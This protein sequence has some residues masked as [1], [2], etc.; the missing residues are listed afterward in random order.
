MSNLNF[1]S[2]KQPVGSVSYKNG[3]LAPNIFFQHLDSLKVIKPGITEEEFNATPEYAAYGSGVKAF[4]ALGYETIMHLLY[5][6][7]VTVHVYLLRVKKAKADKIIDDRNKMIS[8]A[9]IAL[10]LTLKELAEKE[11]MYQQDLLRAEQARVENLK[12]LA[13]AKALKE[14]EAKKLAEKLKAESLEKERIAEQLKEKELEKLK[15]L[16]KEKSL[17]GQDDGKHCE[18]VGLKITDPNY[19]FRVASDPGE[20]K[21]I[22][23]K[24]DEFNKELLKVFKLVEEKNRKKAALEEAGVLKKE[25]VNVQDKVLLFDVNYIKGIDSSGTVMVFRSVGNDLRYVKAS[26]SDKF[27][28]WN[29]RHDE[30]FYSVFMVIRKDKN[31][32][33][34]YVNLYYSV[35]DNDVERGAGRGFVYDG[36]EK[37]EDFSYCYIEMDDLM[38]AAIGADRHDEPLG[39]SLVSE[40]AQNALSNRLW[41][42]VFKNRAYSK[43]MVYNFVVDAVDYSA[44]FWLMP[45]EYV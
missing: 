19:K 1:R 45:D 27:M 5:S 9:K 7:L 18:M 32:E 28:G 17:A 12:R 16:E 34:K 42:I 20:L 10:D 29:Q 25:T 33:R 15:V 35:K 44:G 8:D 31:K 38:L 26:V 13:A 3:F 41:E 36:L 23:E 40:R 2:S 4:S 22:G 24:S 39:S 14:E 21:E 43:E 37:G 11:A 6:G 30:I